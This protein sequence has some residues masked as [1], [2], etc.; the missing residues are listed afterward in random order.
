L[1]VIP[2]NIVLLPLPPYSPELNPV[3]N[4]RAFLRSNYLC[5][6]VFDGYEAIIKACADAWNALMTLPDTIR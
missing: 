2:G 1:G 4:I 3:E 6:R 5:H